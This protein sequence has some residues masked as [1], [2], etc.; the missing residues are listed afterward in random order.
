[1]RCSQFPLATLKETPA[2]TEIVSH[3]LM[4]RAGLIRQV[5]SGLYTWLPLGLRVLRKVADIVR[6][7]MDRTGAV[8]ISMPVVQPLYLWQ[9][10]GR[11]V[12]YGPELLRFT[13]RN[14]RGFCLGPT[15]EEVVSDLVRQLVHSYRQLP[16]QYYQI[17]T[18]FRD[19]I[20]PRYGVMRAR[21]F[22]MKDGYSFHLSPD[23]LKQTYKTMFDAYHRIFNRLGLAFCAV[24]ADTGSIGGDASHEF[25]VLAQSGED[26]IAVSNT[27]DYAA[28]VELATSHSKTIS[29]SPTK[30]LLKVATGKN[31]TIDEVAQFLKVSADTCVKSLLVKGTDSEWVM[32]V[33]KGNDQLNP[34]KAERLDQ[35]F[36]PLTFADPETVQRVTLASPGCIGPAGLTIPIIADK[37]AAALSD[38]ICGANEN[39]FHFSGVNWQRDVLYSEVVD[40]RTVKEGDIA[41]SGKG[42]LRL[43]RGIEV[44]HIFQLG[45]KYTK[46]LKVEVL[47]ENTQQQTLWMGCYGIG[48]SRVVAA[49]IEQNHDARGISWPSAIAPFQVAI[50]PLNAQKSARVKKASENLYSFLQTNG[51]E[52]L[53]D[54]RDERPGSK[55]ADIDLIGIPHQIIIGDKSLDKNML[56]YRTRDGAIQNQLLSANDFDAILRTF[57]QT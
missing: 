15:H 19:E 5:A 3:Q 8:E 51:I 24:E 38:F 42:E 48:V 12:A 57:R 41:P 23:C 44:G 10:S 56:E 37:E 4:V 1:M 14:D 47:N 26:T 22:L 50:I 6:E 7:E 54:D 55:F 9:E 11:D 29:P 16:M 30:T 21:E 35:I 52:V 28:N 20:R 53:L 40:I 31:H 46:A 34:I 33:L 13:D 49:A 25:H 45:Q 27:G 18:K 2:D 36:A 17:Q 43:Q 32:L 39:G